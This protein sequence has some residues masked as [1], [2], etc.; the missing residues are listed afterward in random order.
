MHTVHLKEFIKTGHFGTIT[1]G[2]TK[3]DVV[4]LLG[5][6][7]GFGDFGET[8]IITYG[9]Y[10]FF[11]WTETELIFGIQN[12]H[13]QADCTH[14]KEMIDYKSK[15]W[16]IDKWFLEVNKNI[17]F[18]QVEDLLTAESIPFQ[19]IPAYKGSE[20]NLIKCIGSHVTF[21][22]AHEYRLVEYTEKGRFKNYKEVV[23]S[24]QSNFVLN[25]IRLFSY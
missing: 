24:D 23:E 4:N 19:I 18:R 7:F 22:F 9:W 1:I 3:A 17:T 5:K 15:V 21:D 25:G 13:L 16:T 2:S 10:E 14:H 20:E 6:K 11:Y 12:D 8:Q